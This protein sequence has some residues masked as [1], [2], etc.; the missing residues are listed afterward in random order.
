M[1]RGQ[2]LARK[3]VWLAYQASAPV[4]L[5]RLYMR[6]DLTENDMRFPSRG[7][8]EVFDYEYGRMM[9]TEVRLSEDDEV[10]VMCSDPPNVLYQSW[11]TTYRTVAA[12]VDAATAAVD[13]EQSHA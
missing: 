10:S 6:D 2:R 1:T 7:G 5:G 13:T 9:K 11:S 3:I 4:G 8:M 12:L